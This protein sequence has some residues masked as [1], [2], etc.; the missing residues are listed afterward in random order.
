VLVGAVV[1]C[2]IFDLYVSRGVREYLQRVAEADLGRGPHVPMATV[3]D[4]AKHQGAVSGTLWAVFVVG[5][6]WT[7]IALVRRR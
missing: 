1:W 2:G 3:M 6:G 5:A 4:R 7:T